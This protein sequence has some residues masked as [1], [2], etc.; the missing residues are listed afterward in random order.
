M[1]PN[2]SLFKY[3]WFIG[4]QQAPLHGLGPEIPGPAGT[5]APGEVGASG[6]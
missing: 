6:R 5:L 4:P 3:S 2:A 1:F